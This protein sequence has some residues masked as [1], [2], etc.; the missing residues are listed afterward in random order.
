MKILHITQFFHPSKGYQE[1][2]LSL[3]QRKDNH[4]ITI[5]SSDDL[6]YWATKEEE[7]KKIFQQDQELSDNHKIKIKR[8]KKKKLISGRIVPEGFYDLFKNENPDIV[9]L[10]GVSTPMSI[11]SLY[12]IKKLKKDN[13]KVIIDD[14]MVEAGSFNKF[15]SAFYSFFKVFYKTYLNILNIKV[16]KWVG[17][18]KETVSFMKKNYGIKEDIQMIP[19]GFNSDH[20][21]RDEEGGA[22]WLKDSNLSEGKYVL[23]IGKCD[24][25]KK[26]IDLLEPFARFSE[27]KPDYSLLIVG[28]GT[29]DYFKRIHQKASELNI[30]DKIYIR[31]SVKNVDIR[32]VFSV[33]SFTIWPHGSSMS[34]LEAMVCRCPVIAGDI[35]VNKERL[36]DDRGILFQKDNFDDLYEKML[37]VDSQRDIVVKNA[38]VWIKDYKWENI[39][40]AFLN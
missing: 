2:S 11:L 40:K 27:K 39:N 12:Y 32:K 20:C 28:E 9:F 29:D 6:H 34:M 13:I 14:H 30:S 16:D 35:D 10:H 7:V 24:E 21:F 33:A 25:F 26:P 37:L 18:S 31:P 22:E 38:E 5:I 15:S 4:D 8:I 19:L 23:Y 3:E 1:N 36:D 17:V